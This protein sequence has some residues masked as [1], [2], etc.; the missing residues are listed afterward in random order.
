[1]SGRIPGALRAWFAE[2]LEENERDIADERC[3]WSN[4]VADIYAAH[5]RSHERLHH[6]RRRQQWKNYERREKAAG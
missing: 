3:G 6:D 4:Y 5:A 2:L 1:M